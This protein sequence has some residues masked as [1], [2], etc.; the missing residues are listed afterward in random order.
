MK[1]Q[2]PN[3]L[4]QFPAETPPLSVHSVDVKQIPWTDPSGWIF[5]WHSRLS[6][7]TTLNNEKDSTKKE[8]NMNYVALNIIRITRTHW[9]TFCLLWKK[10]GWGLIPMW[11]L[12]PLKHVGQ[13]SLSTFCASVQFSSDGQLENTNSL[14]NGCGS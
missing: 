14:K 13:L 5:V 6:N 7:W 4:A 2:T 1:Q 12:S 10:Q 11:F 8:W 9:Q 3:P